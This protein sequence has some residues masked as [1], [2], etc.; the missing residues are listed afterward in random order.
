MG[1]WRGH[2]YIHTHSVLLYS[3]GFSWNTHLINDG[4]L[5]GVLHEYMNEHVYNLTHN[6]HACTLT[7]AKQMSTHV[8]TE[9]HTQPYIQTHTHTHTHTQ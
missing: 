1:Q 6:T 5:Q 3:T 8:H 9:E 4:R 7:H 2:T